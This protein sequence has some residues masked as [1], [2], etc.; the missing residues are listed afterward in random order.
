[1]KKGKKKA[2]L[3]ILLFLSMMISWERVE[4]D[5]LKRPLF[6]RDIMKFKTIR[7]PIISRDGRWVVYQG[8][9]D[10]GSGEV[11][12][13]NTETRKS[14]SIKT[15]KNPVIS[16]DGRWIAAAVQP[17]ETDLEEAKKSGRDI[18]KISMALL[19]TATGNAVPFE[20]I[21]SYEFTADSRW[22]IYR[23]DTSG[24]GREQ[25][26][27]EEELVEIGEFQDQPDR[28]TINERKWE[29]R[30]YALVLRHLTTGSEVR[31]DNVLFHTCDP[32]SRYLAYCT[33]A[34][35]GNGN[36][37]YVRDLDAPEAK[38]TEIIS[39]SKAVY[40]SLSWS[41]DK[42][43]LGF[44]FYRNWRN[45]DSI[46]G[47]KPSNRRN[48][49]DFSSGLWIW[50]GINKNSQPVVTW[51]NL[52]SGWMVPADNRLTWSQD[53]ERLYFGFKP[54][55]EFKRTSD[56]PP[57]D[58]THRIPK[59]TPVITALLAQRGVEVWHWKDAL[60]KPYH[61]QQFERTRKR[62]YTA[63]FHLRKKSFV[64]LADRSVTNVPVPGNPREALGFSEV[65]YLNERAWNHRYR[66]VYLVHQDSGERRRILTRHRRGDTVSMS[67]GGRYVVY[68]DKKHWYLYE[69]G[70]K[71]GAHHRQLTANIGTPF[72]DED[73]DKPG[74]PP[75]YG[76]AGWTEN[77]RSVIIYDKYDVWEF[78]TGKDLN[79]VICLT[80]GIGRKSKIKFRIRKTDPDA[81]WFTENQPCLLTAFSE[82]RKNT[83][84]YRATI[85]KS[86]VQKL[87]Q[88]EELH[89]YKFLGHS[90][91]SR[92][93]IFSRERYDEYPDIWLSEWKNGISFES[94][95]KVSTYGDQIKNRWWG[96]AHLVEWKTSD[97]TSLTGVVI[98]PGNYKEGERYPVLVYCY[99]RFSQLLHRF[100][101]VAVRDY[102]CLPYY[103]GRKYLLF[104]PDIRF[105]V[106]DPGESALKCIEAGVKKL[107]R[108]GLADSKAIGLYGHS[109]GGYLASYMVTRTNLFKAVIVGAPVSNLSSAYNA[110]R[111]RS[112]ISRQY[113]YENAQGRIGANLWQSPSLY[114]KNSPVFFADKIST[115][116]LIQVGDKDGTVPWSQGI[117]LYMA[118][119]RLEKPCILLQYRGEYHHLRNYANKIDYFIKMNQYLEHYL[120][121]E[122]A[123]R[124]LVKGTP[125]YRNQF[126]GK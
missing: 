81:R 13:Y 68:F 53:C 35:E 75:D 20:N 47:G 62:I 106:G 18:S 14:I 55:E 80:N 60:I 112:G 48:G 119:R 92:K 31:S 24:E 39:E 4:A 7:Q 40:T 54:A 93:V 11:M 96:T 43:R 29:S 97:G 67:P 79:S 32:S 56:S 116:M 94:P 45:K 111:W 103:A 5:P 98:K 126:R 122:K 59:E 21:K 58:K 110:V 44:F 42:S 8:R 120:K 57:P 22:L 109:W 118:L 100:P 63:V 121:G 102:P 86:G 34:P 51:D 69:T 89:T 50:D 33:Y 38:Q 37:L 82:T 6:L 104:L 64:Q 125:Y 61:Q 15:G 90:G 83:V 95:V 70:N 78:K 16:N 49:S 124:W 99:E 74:E 17:D 36:G 12:V 71:T 108:Q 10:Y 115:P 77:D 73:H 107:I 19:E 114:T 1:M 91:E 105:K 28:E 101:R 123:P 84:F 2:I 72:F 23:L 30:T 85:G 25:A 87:F 113:H 9:R 76:I 88:T 3:N 65:P 52:P 41:P 66:D 27:D 26:D 46:A 117:E